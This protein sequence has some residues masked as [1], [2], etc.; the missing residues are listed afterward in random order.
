MAFYIGQEVERYKGKPLPEEGNCPPLFVKCT[1]V[2]V[3]YSSQGE[4]IDLAEFPSTEVVGYRRGYGAEHFRPITSRPTS[5]SI[6]TAMLGP[7][8]K[9]RENA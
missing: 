2:Y 3:N 8:A 7:K 1:V 6:F 5:I 9:E 4:E